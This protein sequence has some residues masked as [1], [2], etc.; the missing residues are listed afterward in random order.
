[1]LSI[2]RGALL[3]VH[4]A[5]RG[6]CARA[7][8]MTDPPALV[9]VATGA[10]TLESGAG[11]ERSYKRI[12]PGVMEEMI[13]LNTIGPALIDIKAT[14]HPNAALRL[15]PRSHLVIAWQSINVGL[16]SGDRWEL[17]AGMTR[18]LCRN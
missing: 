16:G 18:K 12:D 13:R 11:P 17:Q 1:M 3:A 15:L 9:I 8:S 5:Y 2:L 7:S 6:E 10:L 14:P 4:K